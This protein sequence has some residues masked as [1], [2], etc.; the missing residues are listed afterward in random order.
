M[1]GEAVECEG[2][3]GQQ[4]DQDRV[5]EAEHRVLGRDTHQTGGEGGGDAQA[6]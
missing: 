3:E 1:P 2:E 4:G 5:E 6:S